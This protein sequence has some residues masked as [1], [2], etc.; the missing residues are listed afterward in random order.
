MIFALTI[1]SCGQKD[2][3]QKQNDT[4]QEFEIKGVKEIKADNYRKF[5]FEN[6]K[7]IIVKCEKGRVKTRIRYY[8]KTAV[9]VHKSFLKYVDFEPKGDTLIINVRKWPS[10]DT[11]VQKLINIYLPDLE[12]LETNLVSMTILDFNTKNL[13]VKSISSAY[14]FSTSKIENLE[15]HPTKSSNVYID[16]YCKVNSINTS[17]DPSS[18]LSSYAIVSKSFNIK[19]KSLDKLIIQNVPS[20][21]FTWEKPS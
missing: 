21:I 20:R 2:A 8:E 4:K 19:A 1:I 9:E 18:M 16:G 14:R 11:E 15:I 17:L 7:A 6:P 3:K 13:I 10:G 5:D 12:Y